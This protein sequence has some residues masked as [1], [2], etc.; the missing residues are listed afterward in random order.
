MDLDQVSWQQFAMV[1]GAHG[2]ALLSP[3]PD[4]FLV[5]RSGARFGLR[6]ATGVCIGIALG[7]GVYIALALAGLAASAGSH[8]LF[9]ALQWAG[10]T[11][12]LWLG[13]KFLRA[14]GELE[15]PGP[16]SAAPSL[17]GAWLMQMGT[18][19]LSA[20]LN[21]KNGLF[22]ASL[23]AVLASHRTSVAM[24]AAYGLWM[25]CAVLA[26]DLAVAAAVG[27]PTLLRYFA[28]SVRS[29]ERVT[30]IVLWG[31]AAGV[32]VDAAGR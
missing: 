27:H 26:W 16:G 29:V 3:G 11:Y 32:A 21:P 19:F 1:A 22:Y 15:L 10:C 17:H 23:F 30:G 4:F 9:T 7:N 24:Q 8:G 20:I 31:V 2:L 13:W 12:L 6:R 14:R 25:F 18:G 5:V 28:R